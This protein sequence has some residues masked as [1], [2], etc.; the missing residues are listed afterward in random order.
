MAFDW[1]GNVRQLARVIERALALAAGPEIG[2]ADLPSEISKIA[3]SPDTSDED[4]TLRGWSS[5]YARLMLA[6]CN[7]NK[8]RAC[9][10]LDISF[11]TLQALLDHETPGACQP[12]ERSLV[13]GTHAAGLSERAG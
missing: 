2:L 13:I 6:R 11:H 8:T 12:R 3:V 10:V 1:P 7:G 9:A 4:L 5:R